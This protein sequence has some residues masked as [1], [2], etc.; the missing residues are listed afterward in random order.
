MAALK[1]DSQLDRNVESGSNI[2]QYEIIAI[3]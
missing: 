2:A 3:W 1:A